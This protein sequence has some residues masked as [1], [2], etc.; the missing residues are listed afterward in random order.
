MKACYMYHRKHS[1]KL[2]KALSEWGEERN[3]KS[4]TCRTWYSTI[5]Y[6]AILSITWY[7]D[8]FPN[9]VA[10]IDSRTYHTAFLKQQLHTEIRTE[11]KYSTCSRCDCALNKLLYSWW[12]TLFYHDSNRYRKTLVESIQRWALKL[13]LLQ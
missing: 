3:F 12:N 2:L 13:G 8:A 6:Y 1:F 7:S 11:V 9:I 10:G 4:Y 5:A